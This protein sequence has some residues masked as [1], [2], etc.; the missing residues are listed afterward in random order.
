MTIRHAACL[1]ALLLAA[2]STQSEEAAGPPRPGRCLYAIQLEFGLNMKWDSC[3]RP[4]PDAV[5]CFNCPG[6]DR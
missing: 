6:G 1:A 2:C 3:T 5:R 4:P